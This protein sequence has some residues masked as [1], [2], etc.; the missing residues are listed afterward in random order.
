MFETSK[1]EAIQAFYETSDR[2]Q[3]IQN[4]RTLQSGVGSVQNVFFGDSITRT[5]PLHEFFPNHSILNRGLG[6]D[7]VYGLYLRMDEDVLAYRP[8]RVFMLIGINGIHEEKELILAHIQ[9]LVC[10]LR[11]QDISVFTGSILP[12]R[13]PDDWG[14]FQYQ[15]KI[16][17]INKALQDWS[18]DYADGFLDY[19]SS[20]KDEVGQLAAPYAQPDGLHLTFA[21]Y[22]CMAELVRPH[23]L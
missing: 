9:A 6:G 16:V 8:Q 17:E 20:L 10:R 7:N 5:W 14:R 15:E 2:W 1:L 4:Y 18:V 11:E 23:L 3:E 21:A 13:Y 12:L 22:C 19:H